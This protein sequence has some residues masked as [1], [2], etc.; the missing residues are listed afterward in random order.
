KVSVALD[1]SPGTF[2]KLSAIIAERQIN[3]EEI[4]QERQENQ[5]IVVTCLTITTRS[6]LEVDDLLANIAEHD[7]VIKAIRY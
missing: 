5:N 3:I 2:N 6:A 7:F 1:N 4:F